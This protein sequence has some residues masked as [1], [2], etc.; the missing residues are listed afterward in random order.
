MWEKEI[1]ALRRVLIKTKI[2]FAEAEGEASFYGPKIDIQIKDIRGK[3]D[4]IATV[5]VDYY[6]ANKFDLAYIDEKGEKKPPVIIHRAILGS[7]DRFFAFL[8]EKTAGNLPLWLS[9]IQVEIINIGESQS[10]YAKDILKQL[11]EADIRAEIAKEDMTLG[12]RIREAEMQKIPYIL[13]VG[14]KEVKTKSVSVRQRGKGDLGQI[15][16]EKFIKKVKIEI[17]TKG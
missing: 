7:F 1:E 3:E 4:T 8:L 11:K 5:Q 16:L 12:K 17:E 13:V 9:S 2:K 15:K 6:S 10:E 14:D